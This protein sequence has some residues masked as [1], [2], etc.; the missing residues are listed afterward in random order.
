MQQSI[1]E[2]MEQLV[3]YES[4]IPEL[5]TKL[6]AI[7]PLLDSVTLYP[8]KH[9]LPENDDGYNV[10][11]GEVEDHYYDFEIYLKPTTNN[12]FIVTEANEF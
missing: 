8:F 7:T 5:E 4:T 12:K 9:P 3:G 10:F 1:N 2:S 6:A 11:L